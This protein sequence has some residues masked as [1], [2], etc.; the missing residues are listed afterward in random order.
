MPKKPSNYGIQT[1]MVYRSGL[2]IHAQQVH[3]EKGCTHRNIPES[4][5]Y[6]TELTKPIHGT[7]WNLMKGPVVYFCSNGQSFTQKHLQHY[8]FWNHKKRQTRTVYVYIQSKEQD[9]GTRFLFDGG[10]TLM[11]HNIKTTTKTFV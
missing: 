2:K 5:H 3:Q 1:V 10:T 9:N 7:N 11:S 8:S 4:K 6:A